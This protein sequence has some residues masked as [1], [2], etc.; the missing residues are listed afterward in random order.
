MLHEQFNKSIS[1]Q[2]ICGHQKRHADILTGMRKEFLSEIEELPI[3]HK[4]MR[5]LW[6]Q[7]MCEDILKYD[8]IGRY[9]VVNRIL[10][11]AASELEIFNKFSSTG[12]EF[13]SQVVNQHL[14]N[15]AEEMRRIDTG[16]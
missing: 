14:K 12:S 10:D 4:K 7:K 11:S 6:R 16:S 5:L 1:V 3:A 8:D 15:I 9:H 13:D 2:A